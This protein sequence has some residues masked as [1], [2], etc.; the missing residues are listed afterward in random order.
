MERSKSIVSIAVALAAIFIVW[1]VGFHP[2]PPEP[3][4]ASKGTREVADANKPGEVKKP[5]DPN[6]PGKPVV[7]KGSEGPKE[8]NAPDKVVAKADE[9]P[10]EDPNDPLE[11][12]TS[13]MWR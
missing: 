1:Y 4:G 9:K 6:K 5:T 7:A 8:P 3:A 10:A 12:L 11:S 2:D 13:T